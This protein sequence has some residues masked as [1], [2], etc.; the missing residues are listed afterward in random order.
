MTHDFNYAEHQAANLRRK[1]TP[2]VW[3]FAVDINYIRQLEKQD[4][5]T[6]KQLQ[7]IITKEQHYKYLARK[8]GRLRNKEIRG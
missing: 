1:L 8:L 7:A 4:S 6:N 3:G 2:D 5:L